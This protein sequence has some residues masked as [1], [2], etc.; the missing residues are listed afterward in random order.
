MVLFREDCGCGMD[1]HP[2]NALLITDAPGV[3]GVIEAIGSIAGIVIVLLVGHLLLRGWRLATP[4]GRRE[5]A[6]VLLTGAALV[7]SIAAALALDRPGDSSTAA[8]VVSLVMLATFAAIP[9][10][11]LIGLAR[12]RWWR[13]GAILDVVGALGATPS[14][15]RPC[16]ALSDALGDPSLEVVYWLPEREIFVDTDGHPA[17]LNAHEEGRACI[18]VEHEGRL[19]GGLIYDAALND[20]PELV[21]AVAG[22]AALSLENMRLDAELR[23]RVEELERS[24]RGL[25]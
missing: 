14:E 15:A 25:V 20:D 10:A 19:V 1:E 11:F 22:A 21:V 16:R 4:T 13:A 17:E 24:R 8:N 2:R 9:F 5:L 7:I 23:A 18:S 6:P 12:S 3:A